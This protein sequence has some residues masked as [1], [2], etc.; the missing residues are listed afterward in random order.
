MDPLWAAVTIFGLKYLG[1]PA[2]E[3][4]AELV[5]NV[6]SP[7]SDVLGQ[8]LA[9]PLRLR[10][11]RGKNV[12][13]SATKQLHAVDRDAQK[14]PG[15]ILF[16]ILEKSSVEEESDLQAKWASLLANAADA[17]PS[18]TPVLP[19]FPTILSELGPTEVKILDWYYHNL[20]ASS[21]PAPHLT[22]A[23]QAMKPMPTK[24]LYFDQFKLEAV[25]KMA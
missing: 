23:G 22:I 11:H 5:K 13:D 15:R 2:A 4:S 18:A 19:A 1:K 9:E 24:Q 12:V 8:A 7:S 10:L 17:S 21:T 16:P 25:S 6:L 14:V 20:G 3:V